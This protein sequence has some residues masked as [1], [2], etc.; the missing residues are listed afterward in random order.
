MSA[1]SI[2]CK[3]T[4][5]V[6]RSGATVTLAGH[7]AAG[8]AI[9]TGAWIALGAILVW[10]VMVYFAV[11]VKIDSGLFE[12]LADHGPDELDAWLRATNLRSQA[13]QR[14][15]TERQRGALRL[16]RILTACVILEIVLAFLSVV[17]K[18]R[19]GV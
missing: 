11:R 16:W 10:C 9:L 1:K 3:A 13:S 6:L 15:L 19:P 4:A 5:A 14:S 12:V 7:V 18:V 2:D 17:A 8:L